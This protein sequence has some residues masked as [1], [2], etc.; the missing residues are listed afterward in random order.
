M[1][2]Q[3]LQLRHRLLSL[4][5][6]PAIMIATWSLYQRSRTHIYLCTTVLSGLLP[7]LV[8]DG[9]RG[10]R[11]VAHIIQDQEPV[12]PE[13]CQ[14]LLDQLNGDPTGYLRDFAVTS[15]AEISLQSL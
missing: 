1:V 8:A 15:G 3:L 4:L 14:R 12:W 2:L 5:V 7:T 9:N 6:L 13:V 11:A 10:F